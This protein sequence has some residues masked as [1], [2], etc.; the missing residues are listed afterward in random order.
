MILS[1]RSLLAGLGA[2]ATG[3]ALGPLLRV[4]SARG[5]GAYKA[6]RVVIVSIA[7]GL[8]LRESLGMGEGATMPNLLGDIPLVPGYGDTPAGLPRIAPEFDALAPPLVTPAPLST[9]LYAEGAL[10]TNLRYA[11]GAPGHL[12]GAACLVSGAY[13]NIDNRPDA[14]APAPTLFELHRRAT[15]APATDAWYISVV[16]GFY[17]AL[18]A[19]AH[20][21]YGGRFGGSWLA[22]PSMMTALLPLITS[23]ERRI[24]LGEITGLPIIDDPPAEAAAAR[25]LAAILDGNSPPYEDDGRFRASP[26]ENASLEEHLAALYADPTY[27]ALFPQSFGIGTL[28]DNGDVDATA[29]GITTYHAEQILKRYKPAVTVISLIDID[30]CHDSFNAY[31]RAQTLADACVRHLWETIQS[32]DG[33]R[34]ETAL[35]VVP[36][37]GRQLSFNGKGADSLGRSGLDHGGGDDGDRDVWLLALGPDFKPGVYAPTTI[38]QPGRASGRYETID[39]VM[40]A[41]TLL[42]HGDAMR[43][44]LEGQDMRPGLLM[45]DI[46]L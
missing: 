40:T 38:Q 10:V 46:L 4:S 14:H 7:G 19:S 32:T 28:G 25:R 41:A 15:N 43:G 16:G 5:A 37:H 17:R 33:L 21:E 6:N 12:Q 30:Q 42:G 45:E 31:L 11:E 3:A 29:D 18:Q 36:E 9:P 20:P 34:D 44:A 23:G 8:R 2:A 27:D 39:A 22:P 13:N 35:L 26:V 24:D 1:R